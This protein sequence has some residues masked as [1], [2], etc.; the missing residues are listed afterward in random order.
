MS[1]DLTVKTS[2]NVHRSVEHDSGVSEP[3]QVGAEILRKTGLN[4]VPRVTQN[5]VDDDVSRIT[6][7]SLRPVKNI[8][9]YS[10]LNVLSFTF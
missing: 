7:G 1:S 3:G 10:I 8:F 9:K 4:V 6:L 2:V 5:V